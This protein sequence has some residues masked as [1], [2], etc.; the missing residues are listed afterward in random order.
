MED[1]YYTPDIS[2]F[3]VGFQFELLTTDNTWLKREFDLCYTYEGELAF[4]IEGSRVK[5]LSQEDIESLGF[6][7]RGI[8]Y[9]CLIFTKDKYE[10]SYFPEEQDMVIGYTGDWE[11]LF[12]GKIKNLSELK[13]ILTMV[14]VI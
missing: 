13:R 5:Y 6:V 8:E 14:G 7:Y 2:E 1:K 11:T 10:L 9:S 12:Q 3:F 4:Y